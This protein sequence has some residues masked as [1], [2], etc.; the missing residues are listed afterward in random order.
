MPRIATSYIRSLQ[1]RRD[2]VCFGIFILAC[3][4]YEHFLNLY[5]SGLSQTIH[6]RLAFT[7]SLFF[8][9]W[10]DFRKVDT[11]GSL[12]RITTVT[13]VFLMAAVL[14]PHVRH[15]LFLEIQMAIAKPEVVK[16]ISMDGV[17]LLSNPLAGFGGCFGI[18]VVLS[19]L[20]MGRLVLRILSHLVNHDAKSYPCPHC[21]GA[22][23]H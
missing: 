11:R 1:A 15:H 2:V 13:C 6:L 7:A 16:A 9:W 21:A 14:A 17:Q 10:Y 18:S 4:G 22:I 3:L 20:L 8:A 19:R 5:F 12:V 23:A